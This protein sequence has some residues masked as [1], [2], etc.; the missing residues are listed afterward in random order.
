MMKDK[1]GRELEFQVMLWS[2]T[3]ASFATSG[4]QEYADGYFWLEHSSASTEQPSIQQTQSVGIARARKG[5]VTPAGDKFCEIL[6]RISSGS[7][8]I[9]DVKVRSSPST[10][11]AP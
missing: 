5:D 4:Y 10:I 6:R 2:A 8:A 7:T 1:G 11:L 3:G 9:M